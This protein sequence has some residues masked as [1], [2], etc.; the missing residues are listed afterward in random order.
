MHNRSN[1]HHITSEKLAHQVPLMLQSFTMCCMMP[2]VEEWVLQ[3][4]AAEA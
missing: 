3:S 2:Q 1:T 4:L